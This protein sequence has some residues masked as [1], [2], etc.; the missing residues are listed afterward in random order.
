VGVY[1]GSRL[2]VQYFK[3]IYQLKTIN[4][5][6]VHLLLMIA[7]AGSITF[8][9]VNS[10]SKKSTETPATC[11]TCKAFGVDGTIQ[12][13]VCTAEEETAFRN[14]HAGREISCQ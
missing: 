11:K 4:M 7:A 12:K 10:C 5:K 13:Q 8:L 6:K 1:F 2:L 14:E 3:F 9:S